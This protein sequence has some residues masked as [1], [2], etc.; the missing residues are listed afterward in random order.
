MNVLSCEVVKINLEQLMWTEGAKN[1][2]TSQKSILVCI[3]QIQIMLNFFSFKHFDKIL[4]TENQLPLKTSTDHHIPSPIYILNP[5][6]LTLEID[7]IVELIYPTY[8]NQLPLK[9][10]TNHHIPSPIH[11]LKPSLFF[12][13]SLPLTLTLQPNFKFKSKNKKENNSEE[14][15]IHRFN[16]NPS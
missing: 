16:K 15:V 3:S 5:K 11:T 8:K 9:T 2:I 10:S 4:K 6:S 14:W 13:N 1:V 7:V 12:H